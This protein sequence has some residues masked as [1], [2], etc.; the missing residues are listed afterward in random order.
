MVVYYTNN[1]YS[2]GINGGVQDYITLTGYSKLSGGSTNYSSNWVVAADNTTNGSVEKNVPAVSGYNYGLNIIN[3]PYASQGYMEGEN[4][5]SVNQKNSMYT[6]LLTDIIDFVITNVSGTVDN[7]GNN[8]T[9]VSIGIPSIVDQ[10]VSVTNLNKTAGV[11]NYISNGNIILDYSVS[12]IK[13]NEYDRVRI[14]FKDNVVN[15]I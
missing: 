4:S 9:Y 6:T 8:I 2:G 14:I 15:L 13:V 5:I 1:N 3:Y 11:S 12:N 7:A 10:I